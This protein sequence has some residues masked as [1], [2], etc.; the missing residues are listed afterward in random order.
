MVLGAARD[1]EPVALDHEGQPHAVDSGLRLALRGVV[2]VDDHRLQGLLAPRQ[3]LEPA[4][5]LQVAVLEVLHLE[6]QPGQLEGEV[7]QQVDVVAVEVGLPRER[8]DHRGR[9]PEELL[10][11]PQHA[12]R[13]SRG[14]APRGRG[15]C[16]R[17]S[18]GR[19][20]SSSAAGS[21]RKSFTKSRIEVVGVEDRVEPMLGD[22]A[23]LRR[24]CRGPCFFSSIRLRIGR[25]I[26]LD[27]DAVRLDLE[28]HGLSSPQ[29]HGRAG[30]AVDDGHDGHGPE[31]R[32]RGGAAGRSGACRWGC[33]PVPS[34][35]PDKDSGR[36]RRARRGWSRTAGRSCT[37]RCVSG[38]MRVE[39]VGR[40]ARGGHH[41]DHLVEEVGAVLGQD[42]PML[43]R[44]R[45]RAR[46]ARAGAWRGRGTGRAGA[47]TRAASR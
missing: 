42:R 39:G 45:R 14:A 8:G 11:R 4:L 34:D 18:R 1:L 44:P 12:P 31:E 40:E 21:A 2:A 46:R 29:R 38:A 6:V 24:R 47:C 37:S 41:R 28:A 9:V 43:A 19:R 3:Q 20:G 5:E 27:V 7:V 22:L 23:D 15:C 35:A 33:P 25:M 26:A 10:D 13:E 16:D 36:C 32:R 17:S 30:C